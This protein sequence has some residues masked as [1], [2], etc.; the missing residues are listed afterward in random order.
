MRVTTTLLA[1][2]IAATATFGAAAQTYPAR[3][4][5]MIVPFAAGGPT[6]VVARVFASRMSQT[7][8]QQVIIEN[9]G[10]A[11]GTLG[12]GKAAKAN[13]DGY[14]ILIGHLGT[15]A[16]N[17]ALYKALPYHPINDF[18][19]I[20]LVVDLPI[21]LMTK[22][23]L[24]VAN[25]QELIAFVRKNKDKAF[26]GTAGTGSVS[27]TSGILFNAAIKEAPTSVPYRG[28]GP[29]MNDLVAGQFDYMFDQIP[30]ALPQVLGGTVKA[31]AVSTPTRAPKLPDVPTMKE[32]G[33]PGYEVSSWNAFFAPKR[34]PKP[35]MDRLHAAVMEAM[36]APA[37][38]ERMND[39]GAEMVAKERATQEALTRHLESEIAKWVPIIKASGVQPE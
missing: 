30:T 18:E 10:G 3:P 32:A 20:A 33:L 38:I 37:V 39:L 28:T 4:I 22:K 19:P 9:V 11:G 25:L 14:T 21:V 29:A 27:D 2:T 31:L 16:V 12:V 6:D 8:G 23:T 26:Y 13:P 15:H 7:I 34:T 1:A 5:N 35:V 17:M 36:Q 24:P